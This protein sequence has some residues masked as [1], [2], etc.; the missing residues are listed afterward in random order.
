MWTRILDR[1]C[2]TIVRDG[3][4][5]ICLADGSVMR[6]G[7]ESS[8]P[9]TLHSLDP[10]LPRK[11][12]LNP[13]VAVGEA[14]MDGR[15]T[16]G[17]DNLRGFLDMMTRNLDRDDEF[18]TLIHM[19][20]QNCTRRLSQW[21]PVGRARENVAHH[22]D[23]SARL[24]ELFLDG[25]RQYS[26]A[27]FERPD[28]TLDEAQAAKKAHIARKLNLEP[29]MRVLDIGCGWG[30]M[31]MTLA[32]DWGAKVIGVT[33]SEEQHKVASERVSE[34]G[35]GDR[36]DIR[37]MDY[38]HV[39]DRVDRIVSVGMFEHVGVPHYR[40]FFRHV[41]N[42]LTS[43]G[44]A[45]IH[46]IGRGEPPG[47]TS[48]WLKKYIFP[49]GYTP[50]MSETLAAI[51]KER[52]MTTDVEVW[53]LHYAETLKHWYGRFMKN[54]DEIRSLYDERFVRMFRFYLSAC[55]F[56]FRNTTQAV[57]QFQLTRR[58]DTLP[59]TRGYMYP[60]GR[61]SDPA[62]GGPD[63]RKGIPTPSAGGERAEHRPKVAAPPPSGQAP[64]PLPVGQ[65]IRTNPDSVSDSDA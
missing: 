21:N 13:Q 24:Y 40:E 15:L 20:L 31:A 39:V 6:F 33:L 65:D 51:E 49:G 44:V 7:D 28:M 35:L 42:L 32:R 12:V 61:G 1:M 53:R 54:V 18:I 58:V 5:T 25:D 23:L 46:T 56:T 55:E 4:L 60:A 41:R 63:L 27:Y 43:E 62:A 57:H 34:A 30:G 9:V 59:M 14:Y 3:A 10:D 2:G 50:A 11:V 48:P 36:V 64:R 37:L 22:Y 16:F 45:L 17:D 38:R 29:G 47:S 8:E 26:C 19:F 52:L